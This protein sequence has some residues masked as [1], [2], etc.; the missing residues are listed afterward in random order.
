MVCREHFAQQNK[1]RKDNLRARRALCEQLQSYLD[2]TD[3]ANAD[4]KAAETIMCVKRDKNGAIPP[5]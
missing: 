3:W 2:S 5:L 4:M 1:E